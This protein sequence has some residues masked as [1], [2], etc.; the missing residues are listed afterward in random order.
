MTDVFNKR[1]FV[2]AMAVF[3]GLG[4]PLTGLANHLLGFAPLTTGR[5][6]W[7]AAHN[8]MGILF[9]VFVTW[10]I[11]LNRRML[12]HHLRQAAAMS[13]EAG[14]AVAITGA[15][16]VLA[17]AHAFIAGHAGGGG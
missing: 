3:S 15:L 11:V 10:H 12:A 4:L 2:A 1:A 14:L 6:A 13:R 17:V 16:L 5:H 7:M 9:A 8:V